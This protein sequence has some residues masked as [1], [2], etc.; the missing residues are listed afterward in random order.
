MDKDKSDVVTSTNS[1]VFPILRKDVR[2][3][4]F[5]TSI[6][7]CGL[8]SSLITAPKVVHLGI[9]FPFSN[10]I[11]SIFTYPVVDCI[12]E[13]WGKQVARQTIWIAL[14]CQLFIA[15]IIQLSIVAPYAS[16]WHLQ[17]EYH[18]ILSTGINVVT[19]SLIAFGVSQL[20]DI[21]I[22]QKVKEISQ[23]KQLW[24]RSNIS[25]YIG[26][27]IDSLIFVNIVFINSSQKFNILLGSVFVK[28]ILSFL[29]TPVVYMIVYGVNSYLD[30][31]S[32][33]FKG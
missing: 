26:Q 6:V 20:I 24:L 28:V 29:M 32:L 21:F 18:L 14:L 27:I 17:S 15:L 23:G 12:C 31:K 22:Y 16:F 19:A 8:A 4:L 33:A 1:N 3:Y 2:A 5:L 11:F 10:I 30:N 25:T 13:L 9:N 7:I